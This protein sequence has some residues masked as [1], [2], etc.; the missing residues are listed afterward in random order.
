MKNKLH[1]VCHHFSRNNRYNSKIIV[2]RFADV[3]SLL[4]RRK[5]NAISQYK[6]VFVSG[7]IIVKAGPGPTKLIG[8][9]LQF[10]VLFRR[11]RLLISRLHVL[12]PPAS[13][14]QQST[15]ICDLRFLCVRAHLVWLHDTPPN[16]LRALHDHTS[17]A[18]RLTLS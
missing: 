12:V 6:S 7:Y 17:R 13:A 3:T 16:A 1:F 2:T 9:S 4:L 15:R 18:N 5:Q 10:P 11:F 14:F 8:L